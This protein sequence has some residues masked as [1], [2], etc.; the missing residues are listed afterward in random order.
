MTE[1]EEKYIHFAQCIE[2]LNRSWKILKEI[3]DTDDDSILVGAAFQYALVEYAKS[4]TT[5][6]GNLNNYKLEDEYIPQEYKD[7]HDKIIT[8][9]HQIHAHSDLT[10][11]DAELIVTKLKSDKFVGILQNN[12]KGVEQLPNIE[13]IVDL[14]EKTLDQMYS[15]E[16]QL[17]K[18][19]AI[20]S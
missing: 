3:S 6:R 14:I 20:N 2:N 12:I 10:V 16:E 9:R 7:L 15:K 13:S 1:E 19:L 8:A 4:F 5:S 17:K 11:K 18:N